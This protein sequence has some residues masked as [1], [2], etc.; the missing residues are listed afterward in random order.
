MSQ[1]NHHNLDSTNILSY[2]PSYGQFFGNLPNFKLPH[3]FHFAMTF[4]V[5]RE[6]VFLSGKHG[7]F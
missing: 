3:N 1:C 4:G 2:Y 7:M 5:K 6:V